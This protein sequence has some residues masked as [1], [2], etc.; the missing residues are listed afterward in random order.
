MSTCTI[1]GC[2]REHDSNGL[3]KTHATRRR[4]GVPLDRPVR[5][6]TTG[7]L[8][9]RLWA[10]VLKGSADQCWPW[11][12]ATTGNGYGQIRH[13]SS[14]LMVHRVAYESAF[15]PV[16]EGFVIDHT[17]RSVTC[18]NPAH[19]EPVTQAENVRRGF[20]RRAARRAAA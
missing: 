6:Y 9:T 16:P 18:C 13:G 14:R 2:E 17:C 5:L 8:Y 12:G 3:C 15:G 19:L 1:N 7:S 10:R 11:T 4:R 20:E